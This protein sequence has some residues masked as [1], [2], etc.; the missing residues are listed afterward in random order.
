MI[1]PFGTFINEFGRYKLGLHIT[2]LEQVFLVVVVVVMI[3]VHTFRHVIRHYDFVSG[4][5]GG[6]GSSDECRGGRGPQQAFH[7]F[8]CG[9][10]KQGEWLFRH[11][12]FDFL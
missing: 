5:G 6:G 12:P 3:T 10:E 7:F 1:G 8:G 9:I 11:L 2:V 4:S